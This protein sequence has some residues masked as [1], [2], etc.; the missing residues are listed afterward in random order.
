MIRI[1]QEVFSWQ[2]QK[3]VQHLQI[4]GFS[5]IAISILYLVAA[6]W[7]MLPQFIQ[8]VTPQLLLLLSALSSVFLVKNDSLIQCLHA[9]CGL[10]IG[11][12]LAVIGQIYQTGADSYLLFLI[13]SVLLLPWLYRANIGIFL[14]LC[15][16]SQIALFLFFKQTFWGDEY[17]TVFLLCIHFYA[18][19][20]FLFCIRYYPK[21][22]YLFITYFAV[23][24]VWSMLTFLYMDKGWVYLICSLSLLSIA[25]VYFYKKNDQL[26]S[27]L[28]AVAL[29]VTFT[30]IIVKWLDNLFRQSEI[31]GL[32]IIAVIIFA[33]FALITFLLIKLIPNSRFNNI[34][35][36]VGA[37]I[38]GLVLSSLMLTFWGNF[39]LIMGI[40]FVAF[41]AYILK[42]KQN[43]FLRQLA[44]CL[45]V[46]G[47]VAILFHTYDLIEEVY[48]LLLI[49]IIALVLAYWVRTHWFF[50]FVQLLALYAL[51]VAMI[52][53]DN[54]AH[55]W[56]GNV[57][58]FA[59][60]T[61]LTYVF[62]MALLWVQKIQPQQYQRS[63]MLSN[64]AMTIFFVGFYA[65]LGKSELGD[66]HPIPVLTYGLPIVWCV[67]FIF[68]HIQNQFNLLA[69]GVL[70]VFGAVLIYYGYFEIFIVLAVFSWALMKKD[71]VTYA[72]A[73]L[74]FI[75]ILWCLYYSL[76]LTF[77]IKSLSIFISGTSLL[78]LSLC[79]MRFKNKVG[80]AQ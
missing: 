30:L 53:H 9:I 68:L 8:L 65:F 10:M 4:F 7:F 3:F 70:A 42:I 32:L 28:S 56:M 35:L 76:D 47:Q 19:L 38:S 27:V 37:W 58:N 20:Q 61:L 16:V 15:I 36:A 62:Y 66:I 74:A 29:G 75:I 43:L 14:M 1:Q 52:W 18:L 46:A 41:A 55:F 48:P 60:L 78:L 31:M 24:S 2:D 73:L 33:W 23:L 59:Y 64:L 50:V 17:P 25:F 5:L 22:K 63:L 11:L 80:I 57:E 40:I 77:L 49:Q 13:W 54:A 72:F 44:Y 34:P 51:G 79:L 67:C 26:C 71:K 69:Q 39:S 6:N 21:L 45:F 12:S